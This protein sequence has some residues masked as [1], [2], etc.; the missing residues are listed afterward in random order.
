MD[1]EEQSNESACLANLSEALGLRILSK[2]ASIAG[3]CCLIMAL[4][5]VQ[6]QRDPICSLVTLQKTYT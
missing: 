2:Y 4:I 3:A 6:H 1:V 5:Y